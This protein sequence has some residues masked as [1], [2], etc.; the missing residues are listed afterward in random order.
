MLDHC[1]ASTVLQP[2]NGPHAGPHTSGKIPIFSPRMNAEIRTPTT[3]TAM[4][5]RCARDTSYFF[6]AASMRA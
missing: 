1:D 6:S 3:E 4:P 5:M 2:P